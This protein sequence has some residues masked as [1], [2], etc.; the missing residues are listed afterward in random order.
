MDLDKLL[1]DFNFA[2]FGKIVFRDLEYELLGDGGLIRRSEAQSG[3]QWKTLGDKEI[4]LIIETK[5]GSESIGIEVSLLAD[6][7]APNGIYSI[8]GSNYVIKIVIKKFIDGA[9]TTHTVLRETIEFLRRLAHDD[10]FMTFYPMKVNTNTTNNLSLL[11]NLSCIPS[12]N[13]FL[14]QLLLNTIL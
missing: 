6:Q 7:N 14:D 9:R 5:E 8:V 1:S 4:E 3:Y 11:M 13:L 2:D 12:R 10:Q